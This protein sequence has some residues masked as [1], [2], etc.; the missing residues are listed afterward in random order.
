VEVEQESPSEKEDRDLERGQQ[1]ASR[2]LSGKERASR[3]RKRELAAQHALSLLDRQEYRAVDEGHHHD[4]EGEDPRYA[5]RGTSRNDASRARGGHVQGHEGGSRA[6]GREGLR[7]HLR[8]AL[9]QLGGAGQRA[10]DRAQHD[11]LGRARV[12]LRR[13][14]G[15]KKP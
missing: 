4:R 14:A 7:G 2:D 8:A 5:L 11:R 12:V 13:I 10:D 3:E 9:S 6:Q 15:G 1:E